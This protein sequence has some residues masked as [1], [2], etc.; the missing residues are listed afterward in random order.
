MAIDNI[1]AEIEEILIDDGE[2]AIKYDLAGSPTVKIGNEDIQEG[3]KK[4]MERKSYM[5]VESTSI[6]GNI[7]RI[8]QKK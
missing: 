8:L 3:Y 1:K 7:T 2:K 6:K 4:C 5:V